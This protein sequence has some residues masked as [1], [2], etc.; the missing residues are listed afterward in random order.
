MKMQTK[1]Q[2]S[3]E[4]HEFQKQEFHRSNENINFRKLSHIAKKS[5]TPHEVGFQM[6]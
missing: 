6:I 5:L 2:N 1:K 3:N 4:K